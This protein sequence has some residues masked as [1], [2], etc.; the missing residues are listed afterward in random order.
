M[1][2]K[3]TITLTREQLEHLQSA[4]EEAECAVCRNLIS[5][6]PRHDWQK[7]ESECWIGKV[8]ALLDS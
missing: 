7:H 8:L 1:N 5:K 2:E 6:N 3:I 4:G